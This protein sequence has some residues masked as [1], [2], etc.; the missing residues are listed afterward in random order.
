MNSRCRRFGVTT[1]EA[2]L[3]GYCMVKGSRP[4]FELHR[5]LG[6]N[7]STLTAIVDRLEAKRLLVRRLNRS[8]RRSWLIDLTPKGHVLAQNLRV[9]Y[10]VFESQILGRIKPADLRGFE[11]VMAA[12]DSAA[13]V[14][15]TGSARK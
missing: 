3:L 9:V 10:A 4:F 1:V 7:K 8:D 15:L 14:T 5:V 12:I 6:Q 13:Q 11:A 2:H